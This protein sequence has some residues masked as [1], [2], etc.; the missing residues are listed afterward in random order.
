MA[1]PKPT[2]TP[3][4]K[5]SGAN[6]EEWQRSGCKV[7]YRLDEWEAAELRRRAESARMAPNAY[8]AHVLRRHLGP[9]P[10]L[11]SRMTVHRE[12]RDAAA[13]ARAERLTYDDP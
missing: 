11:R 9:E 1:R 12:E 3:K 6:I 8:A 13:E 2:P 7:Q 5:A 10:P 4:K